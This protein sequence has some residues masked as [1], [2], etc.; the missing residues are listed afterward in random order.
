[1]KRTGSLA[2]FVLLV[3]QRLHSSVSANIVT[4]F[5]VPMYVPTA[6]EL[7]QIDLVHVLHGSNDAYSD[8][9]QRLFVAVSMQQRSGASVK[10]GCRYRVRLQ[11]L[12][13]TYELVASPEV[14]QLRALGCTLRLDEHGVGECQLAVPTGA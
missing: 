3:I 4:A 2:L 11:A 10:R 12:S 7:A 8:D 13:E 14:S 5:H 9:W 1:M 6:G